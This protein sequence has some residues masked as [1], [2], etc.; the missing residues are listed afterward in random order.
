MQ[1]DSLCSVF[2]LQFEE[3]DVACAGGRGVLGHDPAND[4]VRADVA[5][6]FSG[7]GLDDSHGGV[8]AVLFVWRVYVD[9]WR[10]RTSSY[11]RRVCGGSQGGEGVGEDDLLLEA[12]RN[13][14]VVY[15]HTCL[16]CGGVWVLEHEANGDH[17]GGEELA[18][19][20]ASER[21]KG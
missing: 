10:R 17:V 12:G 4:A 19:C 2:V 8:Y 11:A 13:G 21:L 16:V 3:A 14:V 15:A 6:V 1:L 9:R 5:A 18:L 20:E 7:E